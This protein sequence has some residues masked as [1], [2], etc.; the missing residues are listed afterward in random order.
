[1]FYFNDHKLSVKN[2]SDFEGKMGNS[3]SFIFPFLQLSLKPVMKLARTSGIQKKFQK[4]QSMLT[5][6]MLEKYQSKS[7]EAR[8]VF[9]GLN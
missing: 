2:R 7:N 6:G 5:C 3:F 8:N 1:M 9:K 4:E